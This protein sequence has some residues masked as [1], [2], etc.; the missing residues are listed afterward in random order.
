M[1]D[2]LQKSATELKPGSYVI[3][4]N[5][6]CVVKDIQISKTGKHGHAKARVEAVGLIEDKKIIK[7]MPGSDKVIVPIVEKKTAQVLAVQGDSA[8]LMDTSSYE[9]FDLPIPAELKERIKEGNQV[10]YWI[11]MGQKVI[12]EAK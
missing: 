12:K 3:F 4:D 5:V 8:N 7:V 6:P 10:S 1:E 11:V 2:T 9:T